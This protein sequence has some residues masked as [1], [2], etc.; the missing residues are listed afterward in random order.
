M[1]GQFAH[2]DP[3]Q[4]IAQG[5]IPDPELGCVI[6]REIY[7]QVRACVYNGGQWNVQQNRCMSQHENVFW[8]S[9]R[10]ICQSIPGAY[11]DDRQFICVTPQGTYTASDLVEAAEKPG[12][13]S[14]HVM[15]PEG[16]KIISGVEELDCPPGTELT[17]LGCT[18]V[19]MRRDVKVALVG[20]GVLGGLLLL[21]RIF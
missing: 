9:L 20:A 21:S 1:F 17:R 4:C 13:P 12:C 19:G 8:N 7:P 10:Q 5:G 14:G 2:R 11:W 16:C 3:M 15:T 18:K 6:P